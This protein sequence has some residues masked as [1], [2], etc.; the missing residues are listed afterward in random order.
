MHLSNTINYYVLT[1]LMQYCRMQGREPLSAS[2]SQL[3]LGKGAGRKAYNMN[4]RKVFR[5][6][7]MK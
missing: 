2:V 1:R 4:T 5:N 3:V 7:W 6:Y